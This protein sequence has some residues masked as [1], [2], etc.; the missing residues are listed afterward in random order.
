M[1]MGQCL[2]FNML[3]TGRIEKGKNYSSVLSFLSLREKILAKFLQERA[4]DMKNEKIWKAQYGKLIQE[5]EEHLLY[6]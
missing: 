1:G 3:A 2:L 6:I 5:S 4:Q